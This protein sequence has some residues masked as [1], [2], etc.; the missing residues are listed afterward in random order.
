MGSVPAGEAGA[1]R[2]RTRGGGGCR[3]EKF[4]DGWLVMGDMASIN[5]EEFLSLEVRTAG[6]PH[7]GG[8]RVAR[9]AT[10]RKL[11]ESASIAS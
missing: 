6:F 1:V 7:M 8:T 5:P 3:A 9:A 2:D 4:V 10:C 11:A